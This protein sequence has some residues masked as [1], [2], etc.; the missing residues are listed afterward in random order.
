MIGVLFPSAR[1]PPTN[2]ASP[3]NAVGNAITSAFVGA[4]LLIAFWIVLEKD[5][6]P[7]SWTTVP[8][9]SVNRA[10]NKSATFWK[11]AR[12]LSLTMTARRQ[13]RAYAYSAIAARLVLGDVAERER[14]PTLR[15]E[16]LRALLIGAD[17][18]RERRACPC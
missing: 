8:P 11:Y 15:P 12:R 14:Q 3:S 9:S 6:K 1:R 13:P 2:G 4:T 10:L 18:R 16:A 7:S 5:V 17:A